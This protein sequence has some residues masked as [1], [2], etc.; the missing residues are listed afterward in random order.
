LSSAF[1]LAL[2][3]SA[4][5]SFT[6]ASARGL[7]SQ[8]S[9]TVVASGSWDGHRWTL[10]A[11]DD[12]RGGQVFHCYQISVDYPFT[13]HAPSRLP[14]CTAFGFPGASSGR[15]GIAYYTFRSCPL[16]FVDGEL[17]ASAAH[18]RITLASGAVIRARTF[19]PPARLSQ[20]VRYFV[21]RVP[22]GSTVLHIAAA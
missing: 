4:V 10:R 12:L 18:V 11:R 13:T 19:T 9:P 1:G 2:I 3:A 17:D 8:G 7:D 5:A 16:S 21:S 20:D 15:P 22:C 6:A 14:N